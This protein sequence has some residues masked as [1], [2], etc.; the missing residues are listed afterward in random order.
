MTI[1]TAYAYKGDDVLYEKQITRT[2]RGGAIGESVKIIPRKMI[3]VSDC[4]HLPKGTDSSGRIMSILYDE[5]F[6][7]SGVDHYE[8]REDLLD[9]ISYSRDGPPIN[10]TF[11]GGRKKKPFFYIF[12][13]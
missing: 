8:G 12:V 6:F 10:F 2:F 7:V 11:L 3:G 4:H 1:A 9:T 13:V 5:P